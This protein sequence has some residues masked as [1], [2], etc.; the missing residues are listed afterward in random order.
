MRLAA[1]DERVHLA[2]RRRP[3]SGASCAA[4]ASVSSSVFWK[5]TVSALEVVRQHEVVIVEHLAQLR[6][7]AL[8]GRAGPARGC[9]RRATLSSYAGPMPRPVV[10]IFASP[11]ARSRA[12]SSATWYGRMSGHASRDAQLRRAR[13]RRPP[14]ARRSPASAPRGDTHHAVADEALAPAGAGC[15]TGSA[16]GPSC[17]RSMTS[18]WPGVVAAL[19]AHDARRVVGEPVD[20]LALALVAPLGADDDDVLA[21]SFIAGVAHCACPGGHDHDCPC[22]Q[23]ASPHVGRGADHRGIA[24]DDA[25]E[26]PQ[27]QREAGRRPRAPERLAELVVAAAARDR[28]RAAR[29]EQPRRS[30]R[31]RNDSRPARRGRRAGLDAAAPPRARARRAPSSALAIAG[32]SGRR[33]RASREHV[34]GRPYSVGSARSASRH[35]AGSRASARRRRRVLPL[36]RVEEVGVLAAAARCPRR[37]RA[38][39]RRRRGRGRGAARSMPT[40]AQ[41]DDQ[42]R[43]DL[44]VAVDAPA[45]RRAR[46]RSG[47][48]RACRRARRGARV[49]HAAAVAQAR[50]ARLVEQVRVD[51]RDLRRDGRRAR[52]SCGPRAGRPA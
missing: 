52:P 3:P 15:P 50:D 43:D 18:V 36:H 46:R 33:A 25:R 47:S 10:P 26:L 51:A 34:R 7:E 45:R 17:G 28:D 42:Q 32:V 41:A 31:S 37:R 14:R 40:A 4:S 19:E 35:A 5:S 8:A 21:H 16:A 30:R 9:A 13:R 27:V 24:R 29:R 22:A 44:A 1:R 48:A 6:G 38:R 39:G 49:Q 2:R 20:D 11:F 23:L 12:W